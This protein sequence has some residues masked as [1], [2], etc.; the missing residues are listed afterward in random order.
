MWKFSCKSWKSISFRL[1]LS[2][3]DRMTFYC[4]IKEYVI[5]SCQLYSNA[6]IL[7]SKSRKCFSFQSGDYSNHSCLRTL[8]H[9]KKIL[10]TY[11]IITCRAKPKF[12]FFFYNNYFL[13][14]RVE[15]YYIITIEKTTA[16]VD[17][18]VDSNAISHN[19]VAPRNFAPCRNLL[20]DVESAGDRDRASLVGTISGWR[21]QTIRRWWS[22]SA[23]RPIS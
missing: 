4:K 5:F 14:D 10:I 1:L 15:D 7:K 8:V 17:D 21:R 6:F 11:H 19:R 16:R 12:V 18:N 20:P 9:T 22:S 2:K 13:G 3:N 23:V